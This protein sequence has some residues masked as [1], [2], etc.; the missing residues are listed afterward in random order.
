MHSYPM[1]NVK[2]P[3]SAWVYVLFP[4]SHRPPAH[5][6]PQT[7]T[8]TVKHLPAILR[9]HG[10]CISFSWHT[11]VNGSDPPFSLSCT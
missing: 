5:N 4:V 2:G 7:V 1:I 8:I 10:E 3:A 9:R 6:R 11:V